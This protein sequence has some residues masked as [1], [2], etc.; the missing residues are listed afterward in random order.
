[1]ED[2]ADKGMAILLISSEMTELL[3]LS[4]RILVMNEG[5]ITGELDGA[6]ATEEA[7]LDLA[8]NQ[9]PL[10]ARS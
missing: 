5:R 6:T 7:V 4:D 8:M 1:V 3:G 2:L 10:K 9:S